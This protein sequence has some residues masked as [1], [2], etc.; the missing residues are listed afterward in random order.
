M[1]VNHLVIIRTALTL[2]EPAQQTCFRTDA[3]RSKALA[4]TR[5]CH[6]SNEVIRFVIR[7]LKELQPRCTSHNHLYRCTLQSLVNRF[8]QADSV[9]EPN[10]FDIIIFAQTALRYRTSPR[11][12]NN[13]MAG[14]GRAE[15][16]VVKIVARSNTNT[17]ENTSA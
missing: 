6:T 12:V 5:T 11:S 8:T 3:Y 16:R 14:Q 1:R 2:A 15:R 13:N 7:I 17:N 9:I 4:A 10:L